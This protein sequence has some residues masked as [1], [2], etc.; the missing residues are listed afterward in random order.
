MNYFLQPR[1]GMDCIHEFVPFLLNTSNTHWY[2]N[3]CMQRYLQE[4]IFSHKKE[5][6]YRNKRL[7]QVALPQYLG[8]P[9]VV[10]PQSMHKVL[11]TQ[12]KQKKISQVSTIYKYKIV[13]KKAEKAGSSYLVSYDYNW[14]TLSFKLNYYR[15]QSGQRRMS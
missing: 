4:Q 8:L 12:P 10:C 5:T 15:F 2:L 13:G 3:Y 9:Q 7:A 1:G 6:D 14:C 11:L